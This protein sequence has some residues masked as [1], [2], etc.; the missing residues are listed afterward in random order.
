M[1][2]TVTISPTVNTAHHTNHLTIISII[3]AASK[4]VAIVVVAVVIS[5]S[6]VKILKFLRPDCVDYI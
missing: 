3:I 5:S 1:T 4:N 2:P 6:S